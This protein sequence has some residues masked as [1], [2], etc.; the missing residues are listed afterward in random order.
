MKPLDQFNMDK[1]GKG[2][3][4]SWCRNPCVLEYSR[5]YTKKNWPAIVEKRKDPKFIEKSRARQKAAGYKRNHANS[6]YLR[7]F[8]I[9]IDVYEGMFKRQSG[10]CAVC[11]KQNLNG[12]RLAVDHDHKTGIVRALLCDVC[13][14]TL[15]KIGED[16]QIL[17]AMYD[18][19][20]IWNRVAAGA[21]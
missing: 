6:H 16:F 7:K 15:G 20:E 8:G 9:T 13:N 18:Y 19:L 14:T 2:G 3:R 5:A 4:G 21:K 12:K 1:K 11:K 17:N 10:A